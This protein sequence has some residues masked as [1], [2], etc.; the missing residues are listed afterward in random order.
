MI[1]LD[2]YKDD[3]VGNW[4]LE[5][6]EWHCGR[7]RISPFLH[8]ALEYRGITTAAYSAFWVCERL[9]ETQLSPS[10]SQIATVSPAN[11]QQQLNY[12]YEWPLEFILILIDRHSQ[13]VTLR[14]GRWGTAPV[15]I[16]AADNSL[17]VHWNPVHLYGLINQKLD[18]ALAAQ[19][20]VNCS[21][22]Y[23]HQTLFSGI[24]LLTER[25]C[26]I[27]RPKQ[28]KSFHLIYPDSIPSPKPRPVKVGVDVVEALRVILSSSM[29]RW[30]HTGTQNMHAELSGGLDSSLVAIVGTTLVSE[31]VYTYGLEI[32][33]EFAK[34]QIHRRNALVQKY[35]FQDFAVPV[36]NYL[37]LAMQGSFAQD[38]TVFP[39]QE[40]YREGFG[41]L[42]DNVVAKGGHTVFTGSGGDELMYPHWRELKP[43]EQEAY[44]HQV[45]PTSDSF[46]TYLTQQAREAYLDK[47]DQYY[48][49]P[50]A[51]V[52]ASF[53]T[54]NAAAAP[55]YL[56]RGL[57][58]VNPLMTPEL[59]WF[60]QSLPLK[61]RANRSLHRLVLTRLGCPQHVAYPTETEDFSTVL[62]N[63][64]KLASETLFDTLFT[65]PRI[66]ELG[67]VKADM[68]RTEQQKFM[69][70]I[71]FRKSSMLYAAAILELSVQAIQS[72]KRP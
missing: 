51:G 44:Y 20:L 71:T 27:W 16:V 45:K 5:G 59:Y 28:S 25:S 22:P 17:H 49:A 19:F 38:K 69:H 15:Y 64:M 6:A 34:G 58:P 47:V 42:L 54:A 4:V 1:S 18:L 11:F 63:A 23:C 37:P 21:I 29:R 60:C 8:P 30:L 67:L 10:L 40:C 43:Q 65:E 26:A 56:E 32:Q 72:A 50:T 66:A 39:W 36:D 7:S 68:L 35:H 70:D 13:E 14:A 53:F 55:L 9:S 46:P 31:D 61:L 48:Q 62:S 57:W 12:L 24:F 52:P 3:L 33:G 2:I 41:K